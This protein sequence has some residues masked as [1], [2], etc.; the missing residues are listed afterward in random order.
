LQ[1]P[2]GGNAKTCRFWLFAFGEGEGV[3]KRALVA[4]VEINALMTP[5]SKAFSCSRWKTRTRR[6]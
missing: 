1:P 4:N 5:E 3:E 6:P 2:I